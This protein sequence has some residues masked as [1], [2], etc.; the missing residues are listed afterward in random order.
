MNRS[1]PYSLV[2]YVVT[3]GTRGYGCWP[4]SVPAAGDIIDLNFFAP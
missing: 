3:N 4:R 2:G 1:T